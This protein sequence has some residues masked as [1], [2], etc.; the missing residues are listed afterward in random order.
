MP[1]HTRYGCLH[2]HSVLE[3]PRVPRWLNLIATGS[4]VALFSLPL[5]PSANLEAG[6]EPK[7]QEEVGLLAKIDRH[8]L[9]APKKVEGSIPT[10]AEYLIRPCKTSKEKTRAIFRWVTDRIVYNVEGLYSGKLGDNSATAVLANRKAVCE[11]YANL[12]LALCQHAK[13]EAVKISGHAH[14][15]GM[16]AK[17]NGR[18]LPGIPHSWNAVKINGRWHLVEP[19]W[20]AGSLRNNKYVQEFNEYYFLPAHDQ[21]IFSHF[22]KDTRWQLLPK[23]VSLKEFQSLS[24]VDRNLFRLGV[25]SQQVRREMKTEVKEFVKP[26]GSWRKTKVIVAPLTFF[27]KA[28][29]PY[30]FRIESEDA[31]FFVAIRPEKGRILAY[32][33][34]KEKSFEMTI[35][36]GPGVLFIAGSAVPPGKT[37]RFET[38]LEYMVLSNAG[39]D[40]QKKKH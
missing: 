15:K 31:P 27:L 8:A 19:T 23:T 34:K 24:I 1:A 16:I 3:A 5:F 21:L 4:I 20:G 29:E 38:M 32:A 14:V 33:R 11:G 17:S 26:S 28:G 18:N 35:K 12:F 2:C 25:T 39:V 30:T 10:L 9:A 22:P 6:S 7:D 13:V 37:G 36:P 40:S